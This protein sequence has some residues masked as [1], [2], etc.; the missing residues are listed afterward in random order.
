M[1]TKEFQE[2][3]SAFEK[4]AKQ[5][6]SLGSMGLQREPRDKW[7]HQLYYCDGNANNAFKMFQF[8]VSFGKCYYRD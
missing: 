2:I 5:L 8:G 3:M 1:E 7:K 6:V 4:Y